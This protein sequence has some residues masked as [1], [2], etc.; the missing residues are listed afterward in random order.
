MT[1]SYLSAK[2]GTVQQCEGPR[3]RPLS[4]HPV[5]ES[6]VVECQSHGIGRRG[7]GRNRV[8]ERVLGISLHRWPD[9]HLI[10]SGLRYERSTSVDEYRSAPP[11]SRGAP[12]PNRDRAL[13]EGRSADTVQRQSGGPRWIVYDLLQWRARSVRTGRHDRQQSE[14]RD[15]PGADDPD[16][17]RRR[18]AID[19]T[20]DAPNGSDARRSSLQIR[21]R[22]RLATPKRHLTFDRL[23]MYSRSH[24]RTVPRRTSIRLSNRTAPG[25]RP[26]S[27]NAHCVIFH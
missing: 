6:T 26:A 24:S 10:P 20:A 21:Q 16:H 18:V 2:T 14:I 11:S 1:F 7:E 25:S 17:E 5:N 27:F 23:R 3:H 4:W 19:R 13:L 15:G 12:P 9:T 22:T 8:F